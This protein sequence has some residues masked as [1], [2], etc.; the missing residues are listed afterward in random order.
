MGLNIAERLASQGIPTLGYDVE[1]ARVAALSYATASTPAEIGRT[2][3]TVIFSLPRAEQLWDAVESVG[4]PGGSEFLAGTC[5][6][7]MG[8]SV[9]AVQREVAE[10]LRCVGVGFVDAPVS[11]GPSGAR[12]GTLLIAVGGD[13]DDRIQISPML[14]ALSHLV[15]HA[16]PV[17]S[18]TLIKLLNN[19]IVATTILAVNEAVEVAGRHG[20]DPAKLVRALGAGSGRSYVAQDVTGHFLAGAVTEARFTF[21][22][23]LKDAEYLVRAVG[24]DLSSESVFPPAVHALKVLTD[25]GYGAAD[26]GDTTP[27]SSLTRATE[28]PI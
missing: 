4:G 11:G 10:Q 12:E 16:G 5:V 20:V 13:E 25:R 7:D 19:G 23:L 21:N 22:Q 14:Q 26:F 27:W 1:D 17:G 24:D 9:P 2:C 6:V 15:V 8:T 3:R 18:G 28:Q